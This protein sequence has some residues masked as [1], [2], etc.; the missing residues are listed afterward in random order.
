MNNINNIN[1]FLYINNNDCSKYNI[2]NF[3]NNSKIYDYNILKNKLKSKENIDYLQNE[4]IKNVYNNTNNK[5]I[6]PK[7]NE[8]HL[9]S[10]IEDTYDNDC[11]YLNDNIDEQINELNK[12]IINKCL[13]AIK[14]ELKSYFKYLEDSNKPYT[15]LDRPQNVKN[16]RILPTRLQDPR[17]YQ[18]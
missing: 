2:N 12:L 10:I 14:I 16:N 1:P 7:Q 4:M 9:L 11:K 3:Y 15:N 6:I 17:F 8:L 13:N 5:I 18:N